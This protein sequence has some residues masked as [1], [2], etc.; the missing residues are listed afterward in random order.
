MSHATG[1]DDAYPTTQFT[2]TTLKGKPLSVVP[3]ITA[4]CAHAFE[5]IGFTNALQLVGQFLALDRDEELYSAWFTECFTEHVSATEHVSSAEAE[6]A[7][8]HT[9]NSIKAWT[10]MNL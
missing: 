4:A 2:M 10:D 5:R 8:Q 6:Q 9:Y 1:M 7:A 3:G